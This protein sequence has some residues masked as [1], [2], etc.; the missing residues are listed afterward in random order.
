[1]ACLELKLSHCFK[2]AGTDFGLF[3]I[4]LFAVK[5]ILSFECYGIAH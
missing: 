3:Y 2:Q 1:M 4:T 5:Q